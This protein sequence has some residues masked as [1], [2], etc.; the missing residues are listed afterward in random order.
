[1]TVPPL[2]TGAPRP[3]AVLVGPPGAGKST[4]GRRLA[5]ALNVG[6][7]DSDQLIEVAHGKPCGEVFA[8][9]GEED[10]RREEEKHVA[11][12]LSAGGVVSLGGGAVVNPATRDLLERH[13]VIWVE[14]S[15]EEGVRRTSSNNSRPVLQSEDPL[16]RYQE[17]LDQRDEF[18]R[19]VADYRARTD[20]RSPQQVVGDILG[21]LETL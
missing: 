15:A 10:F 8:E 14:V 21:F 19:E 2:A 11:E 18:Y 12:A 6:L 7:V 20:G 13:T 3:L 17:L 1:M 9:L 16:A 5:R 4:I